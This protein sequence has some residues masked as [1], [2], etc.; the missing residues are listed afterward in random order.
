MT[1]TVVKGDN[2]TK[3]AKRYGTTVAAIAEL[4]G[5]ENPNKIKVG[6]VL[7]IPGTAEEVKEPEAPAEAPK[8]LLEEFMAHLEKQVGHIYVWG[9]Q[10]QTVSEMKNPEEWIRNRE[11]SSKNAKR[12][13]AFYEKRKAEGM[14][15]IRAYDCSGLIM[16]FL[17]NEKGVFD[18]DMSAHNLYRTCREKKRTELIPG[19]FVFHHNGSKVGHVGVYVGND[20][21]IEAMGRDVGVVK[22]SIYENY[23]NRFG[24]L[25]VW[26]E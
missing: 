13:I 17:Q 3:I 5:I 18:S 23:W 26:D 24:R 11:T 22:H 15:P 19:D 12:A 2:L 25:E 16:S 14:N 20:T 7:K 6:Q 10:G 1:Y 8:S 4:N 21:V 9:A